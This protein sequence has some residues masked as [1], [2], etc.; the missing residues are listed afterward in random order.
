MSAR[1]Q[2]RSLVWPKVYGALFISGAVIG[3]ASSLTRCPSLPRLLIPGRESRG[4]VVASRA[5]ARLTAADRAS[6]YPPAWRSRHRHAPPLACLRD[7]RGPMDRRRNARD[8]DQAAEDGG[9][10]EELGALQRRRRS[11]HL[12]EAVSAEGGR[13]E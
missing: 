6:R 10:L 4:G 8:E 7:L 3:L 5:P 11:L 2:A 13:D 12:P 1:P 9:I